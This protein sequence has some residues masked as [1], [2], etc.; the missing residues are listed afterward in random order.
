M[1]DS[2]LRVLWTILDQTVTYIVGQLESSHVCDVLPQRQTAVHLHTRRGLTTEAVQTVRGH[3]RAG[4]PS[5]YK[6]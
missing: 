3:V 2:K 5:G 6:L 4:P 1:R